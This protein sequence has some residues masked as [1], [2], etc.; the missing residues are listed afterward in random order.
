MNN[1]APA[2]PPARLPVLRRLFPLSVQENHFSHVALWVSAMGLLVLIALA[3]LAHRMISDIVALKS[4][5]VT[6]GDSRFVRKYDRLL[7]DLRETEEA[8]KR[9]FEVRPRGENV[10]SFV[11][12]LERAAE[13]TGIRQT[14]E[15]LPRAAD[16][17]GQPYPSPVIR[18]T[19]TLEGSLDVLIAYFGA[20]HELPQLVRVETIEVTSP[21]DNNVLVH[22]IT[23]ARIAVAVQGDQPAP[24]R[25]AP[26][27]GPPAAP[28]AQPLPAGE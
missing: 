28:V 3:L 6:D 7:S 25:K 21:V 13:R 24:P 14:I 4:T 20:L 12:S 19:L 23:T 18:Y 8:R 17:H 26:R 1:R 5:E 10:V 9:L 27:A 16:T 11:Q 15:V 2:P 22:A